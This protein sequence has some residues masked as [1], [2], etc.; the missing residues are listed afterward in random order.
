MFL[1]INPKKPFFNT[2]KGKHNFLIPKS[3]FCPKVLFL[4]EII[5]LILFSSKAKLNTAHCKDVNLQRL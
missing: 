3:T 4:C 5:L 2:S 1:S